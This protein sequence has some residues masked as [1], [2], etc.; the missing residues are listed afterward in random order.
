M[1]LYRINS[2]LK[3][4]LGEICKKLTFLQLNEVSAWMVP[5][6]ACSWTKYTF[7][8]ECFL[9]VIFGIQNPPGEDLIWLYKNCLLNYH[10]FRQ[11]A[12][13]KLPRATKT[14]D[15]LLY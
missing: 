5:D 10:P 6:F 14:G 8:G 11:G 12:Y 7:I 2:S 15:L 9:N 4:S 1:T 3:V 13:I